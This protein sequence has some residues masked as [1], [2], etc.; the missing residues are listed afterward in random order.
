MG[1]CCKSQQLM[2]LRKDD[3]NNASV[4]PVALRTIVGAAA[5]IAALLAFVPAANA[6][7]DP[8]SGG[9]TDLHMK[10]GFL[11]KLTNLGIGVAG[12]STGQ[13]GGS[14]ISLPGSG[15]MLDPVVAPG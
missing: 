10:S 4:R 11:K 9:T 13:V 5:I 12:V 6:A 7:R 15:A 14:K 1:I 3:M 8:I 2:Q